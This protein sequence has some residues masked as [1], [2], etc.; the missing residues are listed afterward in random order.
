MYSE[1]KKNIEN[2]DA[3]VSTPTT[4][5]PVSVRRRKIENGTSGAAERRSIA[6]NAASRSHGGGEQADRLGRAPARVGGLDQGVDE[7][8]EAWR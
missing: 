5:A 1:M 4:F 2:R 8:R 6:T 7:Q 3:P